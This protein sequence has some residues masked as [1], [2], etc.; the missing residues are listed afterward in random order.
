[1]LSV[2]KI[3]CNCSIYCRMRSS[4]LAVAPTQVRI[5]YNASVSVRRTG[6]GPRVTP[7][8]FRNSGHKQQ[9]C[10]RC[11]H[12]DGSSLTCTL[13]PT[14]DTIRQQ[15]YGHRKTLSPTTARSMSEVRVDCFVIPPILSH[16]A[17][18][19]ERPE[20]WSGY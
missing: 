10:R 14:A 19:E 12:I 15:A 6:A 8:N 4:T 18:R 20:N 11:Q 17:S 9:A 5:R 3:Y 7:S 16:P 2:E 1:M 13:L